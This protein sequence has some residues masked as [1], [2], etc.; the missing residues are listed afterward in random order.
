MPP[1]VLVY[2]FHS[3]A[4]YYNIAIKTSAQAL[5]KTVLMH[6]AG[7]ARIKIVNNAKGLNG[8]VQ[9][10]ANPIFEIHIPGLIVRRL[11]E[12]GGFHGRTGIHMAQ[13]Y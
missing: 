6:R 8:F 4:I 12:L 2:S 13:E 3:P 10:Q 11:L 9:P 1:H 5:N 7:H